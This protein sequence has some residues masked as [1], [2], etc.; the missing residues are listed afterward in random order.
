MIILRDQAKLQ[1]IFH[2]PTRKLASIRLQQLQHDMAD[3]MFIVVEA[4][5]TAAEVEAVAGFPMLSGLFD[6]LPYT[7][8]DFQPCSE[9]M[10]VHRIGDSCIYEMVFIGTD[11]GSFS[12][13]LLPDVEGIDADLL[14]VCR[15]FATPAVS[16]P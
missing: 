11:D 3:S 4:G 7:D 9:F 12:C 5:D 6:G 13:V 2:S 8:P 15:L 1:Q 14:A 16:T 10:E